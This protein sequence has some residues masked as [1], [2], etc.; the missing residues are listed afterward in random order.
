MPLMIRL[1]KQQRALHLDA[2]Q[3]EVAILEPQVFARQF[4]RPRLKRRRERCD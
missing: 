4:D 1:R 3:V 2:P